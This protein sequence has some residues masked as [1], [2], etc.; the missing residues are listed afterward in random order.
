[1]DF[2]EYQQLAAKTAV[3]RETSRM[4]LPRVMYCA[5]GLASEAGEVAGACK[6]IVRD[7]GEHISETRN[8]QIAAEIGDVLWYAAQLATEL[9]ITLE[10][11]AQANVEKLRSRFE[12]GVIR[13][14]GDVR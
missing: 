1:M 5:L 4:W 6:R 2:N 3:Y 11:V 14:E 9:G 12:R 10:D 7:D 8:R 13:G